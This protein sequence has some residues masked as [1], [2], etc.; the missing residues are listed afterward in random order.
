[1][2][3]QA[4]VSSPWPWL[5]MYWGGKVSPLLRKPDRESGRALV[6]EVLCPGEP[7]L[8]ASGSKTDPLCPQNQKQLIC[9]PDL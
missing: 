2:G 5:E 4:V 1:V 8:L 6:V 7:L 9:L 3:V